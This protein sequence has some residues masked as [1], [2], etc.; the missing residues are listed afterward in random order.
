MQ[1]IVELA[2]GLRRRAQRGEG[3]WVYIGPDAET[4]VHAALGDAIPG[5]GLGQC[6]RADLDH[7]R[8]EDFRT[9]QGNCRAAP[10]KGRRL[11]RLGAGAFGKDDQG[12]AVFQRVGGGIEHVHAAVVADVFGASAAGRG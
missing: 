10:M 6:G 3:L 2:R 1:I 8:G 5:L 7:H 12:L 4:E 11:A 9:T